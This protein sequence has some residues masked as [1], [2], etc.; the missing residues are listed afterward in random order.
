MGPMGSQFSPFPCTPL[1]AI[2]Q[3]FLHGEQNPDQRLIVRS[4]DRYLCQVVLV[5]LDTQDLGVEIRP[6]Q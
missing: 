6:D 3:T 5:A 1:T 4:R 2:S